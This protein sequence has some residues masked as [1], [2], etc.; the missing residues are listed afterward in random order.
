M[1]GS[2][3]RVNMPSHEGFILFNKRFLNAYV[4]LRQMR[5]RQIEY[6][7]SI[8]DSSEIHGILLYA[9]RPDVRIRQTIMVIKIRPDA[10]MMVTQSASRRYPDSALV[11]DNNSLDQGA[12]ESIGIGEIRNVAIVINDSQADSSVREPDPVQAI[13]SDA[14]TSV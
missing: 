7:E 13:D 8:S 9:D 6:R 1:I 2:P 4:R 11:V 10:I 5:F 14:K 3:I 12:D